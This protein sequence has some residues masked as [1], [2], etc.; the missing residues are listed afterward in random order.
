MW[1]WYASRAG[2]LLTLVL[3]TGTFVLGL[4]TSGRHATAHW[5]RFAVAAL[6][7]NLS[8]LTLVF[9]AV[10]ITTAIVD[11]YV[12]LGW[13]DVVIPFASGYRPFW[14]GLGAVAVDALLAVVVTS[15][16]RTRVPPK[17]WRGLHWATYA[18]WPIALAHGVGM[19]DTGLWWVWV[20][21]GLC[22]AAVL[23]AL[24]W[25]S[26]RTHQDTMARAGV[27]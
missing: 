25:R 6:H 4:L 11:G 3:L 20:L 21:L 18:C 14:V 19:A 8:L 7:R 13:I 12:A 10:H 5:P 24:V 27:R 23:G 22:A 1:L 15:L 26:L 9:L 2:G 17:V 16:L